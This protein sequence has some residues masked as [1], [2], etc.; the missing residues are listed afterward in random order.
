MSSS[1]QVSPAASDLPIVKVDFNPQALVPLKSRALEE[2]EGVQGIELDTEDDAKAA[3]EVLLSIA[4][5]KKDAVAQSKAWLAPLN[6]EHDRIRKPFKEIEDLCDAARGIVDKALGRFQ[7]LR[8]QRQRAALAAATAAVKQDD[9]P[10]L[11]TALQ[12]VSAAAPVKLAGVTVKAFWVAEVFAPELVPHAY[13]APDLKKIGAH[14]SACPPEREPDP[15]GG[16]RYRLETSTTARP[17]R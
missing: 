11:T 5:V 13:L 10:A 6:A 17:G 14:A 8:A 16:V 2:L 3:A 15:I 1:K 12:T 4:G 9:A 7:L